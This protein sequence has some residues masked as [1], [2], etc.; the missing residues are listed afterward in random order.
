MTKKR[1]VKPIIPTAI[2]RKE[3]PWTIPRAP[4][5]NAA[6]RAAAEVKWAATVPGSLGR[7]AL[8]EFIGTGLL[9]TAVIGPGIA[10]A[11]L[12]LGD[13]GLQL[14][15][16]AALSSRH[17]EGVRRRVLFWHSSTLRGG[18]GG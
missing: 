14:L 2:D 15:E 18:I 3:T 11:R 8:G 13:V 9:V 4:P 17:I 7:R 12:S 10:A 16:D 1:C 6:P 5:R